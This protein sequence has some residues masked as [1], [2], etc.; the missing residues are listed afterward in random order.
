MELGIEPLVAQGKG[1][2]SVCGAWELAALLVAPWEL[3]AGF[4]MD[5]TTW[6]ALLYKTGVTSLW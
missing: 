3:S 4:A 1:W 6:S 5:Y 2:S